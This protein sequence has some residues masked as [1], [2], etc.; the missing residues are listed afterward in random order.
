[1]IGSLVR[2]RRELLR[3]TLRELARRVGCHYSSVSLWERDRKHPL[4]GNIRR[5]ER[6]LGFRLGYL[7]SRLEN[8]SE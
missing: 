2:R 7:S 4:G 8:R 3:L 6:A 5:L 1:M